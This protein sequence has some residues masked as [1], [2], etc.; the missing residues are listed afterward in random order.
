MAP[1]PFDT[2]NEPKLLPALGYELEHID[3]H[4]EDVGGP[5][6][7]PRLVGHSAY[8]EWTKSLD[9]THTHVI[10]VQD[11]EVVD[12]ST[13]PISMTSPSEGHMKGPYPMN[14]KL[15]TLAKD[16]AVHSL[17]GRHD[18]ETSATS[19]RLTESDRRGLRDRARRALL[20][21]LRLQG[22]APPDEP[23]HTLLELHSAPAGEWV[24]PEAWPSGA[25]VDR[26]AVTLDFP[27]RTVFFD[28]GTGT[29]EVWPAEATVEVAP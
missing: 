14:G 2:V 24:D 22:F 25:A 27:D 18:N 16:L 29:V 28:T 4:W 6:N 15:C 9:E 11:G 23:L 21:Q 19:R 12:V 20:E 5:E 17:D 8:D 3:A 7:G 13:E 10:V 26:V 1:F